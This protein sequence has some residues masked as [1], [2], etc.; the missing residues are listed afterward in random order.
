[1]PTIEWK[2]HVTVAAIICKD[3]RYLLVEE[4]IEN[5]V[6]INQPAGHL[7]QNETLIEA[8]KREVLEETGG[9]FEPSCLTGIY[10]YT[11][12]ANN[13]TYVRF[14]FHGICNEFI[15]DIQLDDVIIRPL[16]LNKSELI[17]QSANLRSEIVLRCIDDFESGSRVPLEFISSYQ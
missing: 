14:C 9:I 10:H 5:K 17:S 11:N 15:K 13:I 1:M 2:P 6:V 8:V 3:S 12:Y 4:L 16:W 7:E